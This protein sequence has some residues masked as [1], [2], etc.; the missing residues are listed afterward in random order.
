MI[1]TNTKL[2]FVQLETLISKENPPNL[3]AFLEKHGWEKYDYYEAVVT[4]D[5]KFLEA[6]FNKYF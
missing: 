4:N 6:N 5:S 2:S 3:E 1:K